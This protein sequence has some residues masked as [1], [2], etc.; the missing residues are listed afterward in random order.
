[1]VQSNTGEYLS[2][3]K[4]MNHVMKKYEPNLSGHEIEVFD[5]HYP[6]MIVST[7]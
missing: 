1:M 2:Q 6:T 4:F 7:L 5:H 3:F